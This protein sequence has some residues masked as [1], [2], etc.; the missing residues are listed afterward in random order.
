M[1]IIGIKGSEEAPVTSDGLLVT[2]EDMG[3]AKPRLSLT[4]EKC[5]GE[6]DSELNR[7]KDEGQRVE[8]TKGLDVLRERNYSGVSRRRR[9]K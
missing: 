1:V 7:P 6:S 9:G 5:E 3:A 8:G 4:G 2:G